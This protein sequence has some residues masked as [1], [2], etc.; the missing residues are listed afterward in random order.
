MTKAVSITVEK[1]FERNGMYNIKAQDGEWYGYGKVR[2][3]FSEGDEIEFEFKMNGKYMNVDTKTVQVTGQRERTSAPR[4]R[5][6]EVMSKDDYWSRKE[7]NDQLTQREIRHQASRNAAIAWMDV[8][9]KNNVI[10]FPAKGDKLDIAE[11]YLTQFTD[12]F[13]AATIGARTKDDASYGLVT[14]E[15]FVDDEINLDVD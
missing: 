15:D 1:I 11:G 10:P 6:T 5:P 7:A 9:M 3:T 8:L 14:A 2:P 13:I 12:M 4:T